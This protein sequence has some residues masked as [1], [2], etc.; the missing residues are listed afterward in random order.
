MAGQHGK[1]QQQTAATAT[2]GTDLSQP[3]KTS[4]LHQ[5]PSTTAVRLVHIERINQDALV[6]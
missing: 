1:V 6:I 5:R 2:T 3:A 4:Y